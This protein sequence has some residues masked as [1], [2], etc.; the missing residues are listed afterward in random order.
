ME[1]ELITATEAVA[2]QRFNYYG[3]SVRV[4]PVV[5]CWFPAE[6]SY[7]SLKVAV[8]PSRKHPQMVMVI[9]V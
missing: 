8:E 6:L 2:Q 4:P 9:R 7:D 1:V 5:C 3:V